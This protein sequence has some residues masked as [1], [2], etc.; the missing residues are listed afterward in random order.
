MV[1][2]ECAEILFGTD[3]APA[4]HG[5]HIAEAP[6]GP[7]PA[8]LDERPLD[9]SHLECLVETEGNS[10]R[11]TGGNI[12]F[13]RAGDR[14]RRKVITKHFLCGERQT[15][16][17]VERS[18]IVRSY[19]RLAVQFAIPLGSFDSMSHNFPKFHQLPL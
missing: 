12:A 9:C 18:D 3:E 17:V 10:S 2:I 5:A 14:K 7:G 16:Q 13:A 1:R 4:Q 8:S 19:T 6:A 11:T 15:L